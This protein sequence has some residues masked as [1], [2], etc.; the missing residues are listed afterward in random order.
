MYLLWQTWRITRE[1][2]LPS[3]AAKMWNVYSHAWVPHE[4]GVVM[5]DVSHSRSTE[6]DRLPQKC[7][8]C[9]LDRLPQ[10]FILCLE[11]VWR[12]PRVRSYTS[13]TVGSHSGKGWV[14]HILLCYF[15]IRKHK[16]CQWPMP[17]TGFLINVE[18]TRYLKLILKCTGQRTFRET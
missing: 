12:W 10:N 4:G 9:A 18:R 16:P 6:V 15:V 17:N 2:V 5:G 13:L 8:S 14:S 1:S 11:S 7:L 3:N